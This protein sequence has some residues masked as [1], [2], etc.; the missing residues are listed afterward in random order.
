MLTVP[1]SESDHWNTLGRV[2]SASLCV[3]GVTFGAL[4]NLLEDGQ[5]GRLECVRVNVQ[6]FGALNVLEHAHC[7]VAHI[8]LHHVA[9][10]L[11]LVHVQS[12]VLENAP[13]AVRALLR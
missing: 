7:R 9:V 8:V 2:A 13:V 3:G 1:P 5:A 10:G 6:R 11:A 4:C 12:R